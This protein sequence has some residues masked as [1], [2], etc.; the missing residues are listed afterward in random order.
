M[1]GFHGREPERGGVDDGRKGERRGGRTGARLWPRLGWTRAGKRRERMKP[2]GQIQP[3]G[4]GGFILV[5][6]L[7]NSVNYFYCLINISGDL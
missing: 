4:K 3:K 6:F 1:L 2:L 5:L 7:E